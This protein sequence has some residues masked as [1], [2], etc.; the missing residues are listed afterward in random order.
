[1]ED[2]DMPSAFLL[3]AVA[4]EA[5]SDT[6]VLTALRKVKGIEEACAVDGVYDIIAKVTADTEDKLKDIEL[7]DVRTI[8]K[9]R[10]VIPSL[11]FRV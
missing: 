2:K 7:W 8:S 5:G 9:V 4:T 1:M 10:F 6:E 3:I 11:F